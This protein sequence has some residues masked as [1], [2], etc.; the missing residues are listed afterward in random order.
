MNIEY[1]LKNIVSGI[2]GAIAPGDLSDIKTNIDDIA[3]CVNVDNEV[4]VNVGNFPA[5]QAVSGSVSITGTPAVTVSSGS[6]N[7]TCSG[8]VAVSNF[9]ATQPVSGSVSISGTPAV[10]VSSGS[11]NATCSGTVAVSNFP[12]T[13][14]VSGSVSITGTPAVTVSSGSVNATCSGTVAVSNFPATQP[15]SGT[16]AVTNTALTNLDLCFDNVNHHVEVDT[17]AINGVQTAVGSGNLSTGVQRIC[18]ATDDVNLSAI[19][20]NTTST[21]IANGTNTLNASVDR[22]NLGLTVEYGVGKFNPLVCNNTQRLL[23]ADTDV[24]SVLDTI[25]TNIATMQGDIASMKN[26]LTTVFDDPNNA[27]Q[28]KIVP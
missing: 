2:T 28:V 6:I 18:I 9:P 11:V 14:Q 15:V 5:T 16:V 4:D 23:V 21:Y 20:T 3:A 27:L 12:A 22:G 25:S 17:N 24:K 7:A 8:T 26:I 19:K 1:H 10:T 13:Q